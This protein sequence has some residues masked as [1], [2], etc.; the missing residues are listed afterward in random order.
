MKNILLLV[1]LLMIVSFGANAQKKSKK[2]ISEKKIEQL[3]ADLNLNQEQQTS[4]LQLEKEHGANM[5]DFT[6]KFRE[7]QAQSNLSE[8]DK[9][10]HKKKAQMLRE[11]YQTKFKEILTPEQFEK[12]RGRKAPLNKPQSRLQ[13]KV[14]QLTSNLN[15]SASQKI[16]VQELEEE[17][18]TKMKELRKKMKSGTAENTDSYRKEGMTIK[19]DY[20]AKMKE[21]LSPEQLEKLKKGNQSKNKAQTSDLVLEQKVK[22]MSNGLELDEKQSAAVLELEKEYS[23]QKEALKVKRRDLKKAGKW[24]G[25]D[26]EAF[27]AKRKEVNKAYKAELKKILTPEQFEKWKAREDKMEARQKKMEERE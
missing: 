15:L 2:S 1:L 16:S 20:Q 27:K 24:S 23:L 9:K 17:R 26:K 4:L 5:N 11:T 18:A 13:S 21:I 25:E 7:L 14:E 6:H 10:I 19:K 8:E 3:T 22:D 12:L